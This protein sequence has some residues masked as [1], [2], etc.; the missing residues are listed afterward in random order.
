MA[1]MKIDFFSKSIERIV[2]IHVYLPNDTQPE[3][4]DNNPHYE[5]ETKSLYLLHGFSGNSTDWV[6]GS[7]AMEISRQYN[8]AI[9]MP[10]GENSF[11]INRRGIGCAYETF[12]VEELASYVSKTF[13]LSDAREDVIIGGLSMGAFGAL[14]LGM[15]Y[16]ERYG[17][18]VALSA[19][20]IIHNIKG[21]KEDQKDFLADYYYYHNIFGD[22]DK[23]VDSDMNPEYILKNRIEE[24]LALPRIFMACG[25]ED[26]LIKENRNFRDVLQDAGVDLQ[27]YESKGK[28]N[29]AFWNTYLE[30]AVLWA[31]GEK[32]SYE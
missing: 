4:T 31:L 13:H 15:K 16:G 8:L 2:T 18:I 7:N 22:L 32:D 30:P 23:I 10:S 26:F 29:W 17:H 20:L 19:A 12:I 3:F 24:E 11:Y 28:H 9:V 1:L 21:M 6:T 5:R 14:R 27:Y 25:T